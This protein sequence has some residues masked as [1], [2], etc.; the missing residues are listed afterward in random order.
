MIHCEYL[1][2]NVLRFDAENDEYAGIDHIYSK[3]D[4]TKTLPSTNLNNFKR[5]TFLHLQGLLQMQ[6]TVTD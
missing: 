5:L 2:L 3:T 1:L 6:A 4:E